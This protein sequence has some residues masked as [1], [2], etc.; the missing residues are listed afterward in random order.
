MG[1]GAQIDLTNMRELPSQFKVLFT[2]PTYVF[3]SLFKCCDELVIGGVA[4]FGPKYLEYQF[5]L[6]PGLAGAL[7]GELG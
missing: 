2:N 1:D 6:K 7:F 5:Y 4:V 3:L